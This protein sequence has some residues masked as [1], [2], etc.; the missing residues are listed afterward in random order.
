MA[1]AHRTAEEAQAI[2]V[3]FQE[4]VRRNFEMLSEAVRLMGSATVAAPLAPAP[5]PASGRIS[6]HAAAPPPAPE[7]AA[8]PIAAPA[9]TAK[10]ALALD[11]IMEPARTAA[12]E[13]PATVEPEAPA[14]PAAPKGPTGAELAEQIGLRPRLK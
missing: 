14:G 6:A 4:R 11:D 13:P 9:G 5:R 8:E 7:R 3:A 10:D 1:C 2:D 12:P